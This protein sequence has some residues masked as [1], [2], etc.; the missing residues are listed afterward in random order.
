MVTEIKVEDE[1]VSSKDILYSITDKNEN[2]DSD[3][4]LYLGF[5]AE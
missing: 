3:V 5:P 4:P 2:L 1:D